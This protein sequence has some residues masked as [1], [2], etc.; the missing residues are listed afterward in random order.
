MG[1]PI[2]KIKWKWF[3]KYYFSIKKKKN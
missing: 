2:I 3:R 1:L